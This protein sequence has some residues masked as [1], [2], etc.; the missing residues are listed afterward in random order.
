MWRLGCIPTLFL[1]QFEVTYR[2]IAHWHGAQSRGRPGE[3]RRVG[4]M[5][6]L[7]WLMLGI[8]RV[9]YAQMIFADRKMNDLAIVIPV[10]HRQVQPGDFRRVGIA[11]RELSALTP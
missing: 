3:N 8:Q 2:A 7:R 5:S 10:E 9:D 1:P 6:V 4:R 11:S